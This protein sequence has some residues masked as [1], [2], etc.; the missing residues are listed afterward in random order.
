M[1][2]RD[3]AMLTLIEC[4]VLRTT[5]VEVDHIHAAAK[6]KIYLEYVA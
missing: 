6:T 1:C 4:E 5:T 2:E 3:V